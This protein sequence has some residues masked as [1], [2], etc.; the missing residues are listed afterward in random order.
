LID[1]CKY[2]PWSEWTICN[3]PCAQTGNRTRQQSLIIHGSSTPNP[4]CEREITDTMPCT[5]LP[6][7]CTKGVNCTCELTNWSDWS[8]CS[9]PC[10]NGQRE[11]TR[12]YMTNSSEDCTQDNLRD[13][14]PCNIQCCPINGGSTPWSQWSPCS[15]ECGSG[16][17][18]RFRSCTSPPPSC[19]GK[20][21]SECTMDTEVCNTKPCGK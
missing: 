9:K 2:T 18:K 5:G 14:Q 11:R 17:R 15:A 3:A 12:Q 4:L 16:V 21:C 1:D 8:H 10:G 19:K 7:P 20:P 13:I 6:C